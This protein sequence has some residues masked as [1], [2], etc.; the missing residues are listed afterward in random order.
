MKILYLAIFS[1]VFCSFSNYAWAQEPEYDAELAKK[2]GAD[3]YGMKMYVLAILKTGSVTISD[4]KVSDSLF[5]GHME[6]INRLANEGKLV[7][8]GPFGSND[9]QYRGIF[10]LNV[11][12]VDEARQLV[13]TDPVL[14]SGLMAVDLFPWYGSAALPEYLKSHALIEKI[15]P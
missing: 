3:D 11:A 14:K 1:L 12:K 9:Q 8:A 2:L 4:K 15:K 6:N 7:V 10:I 13:E 5:R